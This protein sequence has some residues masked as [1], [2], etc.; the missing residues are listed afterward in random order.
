MSLTETPTASACPGCTAMPDPGKD[1]T[2]KADAIQSIELALPG[3]HCAGCIASVE[4][5]LTRLPEVSAARV[6]L[7][8]KR[9]RIDTAGEVAPETLIDHLASIGYE[10]RHLDSDLLG[11]RA[12]D[13]GRDLMMRLAVA[14]F[15][16]MNVMLLSVAVWSGAADATRDLFHWISASIALPTIA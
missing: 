3:I 1:A 13:T 14:G 15:A 11:P 16:M 9:V 5:G 6:N 7:S 12:D 8:Q 2:R 10:A 4:R